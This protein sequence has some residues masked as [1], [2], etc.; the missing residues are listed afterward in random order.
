MS[1]ALLRGVFHLQVAGLVVLAVAG[2]LVVMGAIYCSL[3]LR[4]IQER[5]PA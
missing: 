4:P 3:T 1:G 2:T 5:K